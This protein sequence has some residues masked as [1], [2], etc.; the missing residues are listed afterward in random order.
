MG[1]KDF[2]Q[3]D[4]EW[5]KKR[6]KEREENFARINQQ[7]EARQEFNRNL[8]SRP[9]L[10]GLNSNVNKGWEGF[11]K[12][13]SPITKSMKFIDESIAKNPFLNNINVTA[14]E[15]VLGKGNLAPDATG[16]KYSRS[17]GNKFADFT[18]STIGNI[19][20]LKATPV[21]FS[22]QN[23]LLN[24]SDDI[25]EYGA[26]K[27]A[28]KLPPLPLPQA[29]KNIGTATMRGAI[30]GG[31]GDVA[32]AMRFDEDPKEIA[33]QGLQGALGGALM[34]GTGK[35]IGEG[36]NAIRK[37]LDLPKINS[38]DFRA[39]TQYKMDNPP[40]PRVSGEF[41][42]KNPGIDNA[43]AEYEDAVQAIQNYWGH[44]K[45]DNA[46]IVLGAEELGIDL[47]GILRKMQE[48]EKPFNF[49]PLA[50]RARMGQVAGVIDNV[51]LEKPK[52]KY[53]LPTI[54]NLKK[55]LNTPN[56]NLPL[57]PKIDNSF[58]AFMERSK[59]PDKFKTMPL[60]VDLNPTRQLD[61]KL[62]DNIPKDVSKGLEYA[63]GTEF[64][65][66]T[67]KD[68]RSQRNKLY[69][70]YLDY[71]ENK[72]ISQAD[73]VYSEIK[74]IS[75][76]IGEEP[77]IDNVLSWKDKPSL[78]LERETLDRNAESVMGNYAP[79]FIKDYSD[80][81]RASEAQR[82]RFMNDLRQQV[83]GLGIKAGSKES[84]LVQKFGEGDI[85][86]PQLQGMTKNWKKVVEA[87]EFFRKQYDN[88]LNTTNEV[89]E[90]NGYSPIA[91]RENYFPHMGELQ[92]FM[93]K[94]G[95]KTDEIPT[96]ISGKTKDFKPGKNFFANALHRRGEKTVYDAVRGFDNYI[97]GASKLIHQTDN[98]QRLRS[99]QAEIRNIAKDTQHLSRFVSYLDEYTNLFAGKKGIIDRVA[100]EKLGRSVYKTMDF[101][102]KQVGANMV[103]ANISSALTNFIPLTQSVATTSKSA[104][105]KGLME[106]IGSVLTG[107]DDFVNKSDFLTRRFGSDK[108]A[109][110][111]WEKA[112]KGL[113]KPFEIIDNFTSQFIVR[114]KY[115]ELLSKGLSSKQ[116]MK[117]ADNYAARLMTDKSVGQLPN[118]FG[119]KTAGM[120]AQFQS[121]VNNQ[122][123]FIMK[124][125]PKMYKGEK[126][127]TIKLGSAVVQ[128]A[129]YS[130]VA[131]NLFE[132][133]T[134]RR[135]AIDIIDFAFGTMED[136]KEKSPFETLKNAGDKIVDQL[137]LAS[138][139]T[140]GGRI[141]IGEPFQGIKEAFVGGLK[142]A[143][144]EQGG[145]K[146]LV[147]G[148]SK[149]LPYFLPSG[150]NQ[151]RKSIK[152]IG[153]LKDKGVYN[154]PFN[155]EKSELKYPVLPNM[156]NAVRGTLFGN[157]AFPE[158]NEYYSNNRKPLSEKQTS[159]YNRKIQLD[160]DP[161]EVYG[162]IIKE[163][164]DKA[165]KLKEKKNKK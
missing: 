59:L 48:A 33:K 44:W 20:G 140:D 78:L 62:N 153:A 65:G 139:F 91:K 158:A 160:Y 2:L 128:M 27:I 30:D 109:L 142:T 34:F 4:N 148:L 21:D 95:I 63:K 161:I 135:P 92:G 66:M 131:N 157:S 29:L 50:E 32:N 134:G 152:G 77:I 125:L 12:I 67:A 98:I 145:E 118:L 164:E 154:S 87:S 1:W 144:K 124:D 8:P 7:E 60:E 130:W 39:E 129:L 22:G 84:E 15:T 100:E 150:G 88:L 54:E 117:Q 25:A 41:K 106:T 35:A 86:L 81:I 49:R 24:F 146:D 16:Y 71:M 122:L 120:I 136:S 156:P 99:L 127:S 52:P 70:D 108:I 45:L 165:K 159:E 79:Q 47:N 37:G 5:E 104:A 46:E 132:Q 6:Q 76:I 3:Q 83:Q 14:G 55:K 53:E 40:K 10:P 89:L 38:M 80:P 162:K 116:A 17:T 143:M 101:I 90:R 9:P 96:Q 93:E 73:E 51:P 137:P 58:E 94:I 149:T 61:V 138:I 19:G 151:L 85:S 112:G 56:P 123:S 31:I 110:S 102:R 26:R 111:K 57:P 36:T 119:S 28:T 133:I 43:Y 107:A 113:A 103:G 23:N 147:D 105:A 68:L 13:V 75:D 74:K 114:S 18:S 64:E 72:K 126:L 163:R 11:A 42:I 69:R 121:E 141:P 155:M 97:E 82:I 115:N